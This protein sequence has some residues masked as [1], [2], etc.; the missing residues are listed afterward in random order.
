M[1]N[2]GFE[3][4][5]KK[6]GY[7]P[8]GQPDLEILKDL[9]LTVKQG[10]F[11]TI[12]GGNGTGKSTLLKAIAGEI[13][14]ATGSIT[15]GGSHIKEPIHRRIDGVGI[16]HQHD[17]EDL[18]HA[19]SIAMNVAFRQTN[20]GC[21]P[22][23]F[24]A[25][26]RRYCTRLQKQLAEHASQLGKDVDQL[27]GHL[28]G[29]ERQM[30]NMVIATHLEHEQNP[31]RLILLD[32]HTSKLDHDNAHAV[33]EF[34]KAQIN[35]IGTTAIMVTHRYPDAIKYSDRIVVMGGGKIAKEFTAKDS[36]WS[37][38]MLAQAVEENS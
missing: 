22:H 31:C 27:V 8:Q 14:L 5:C 4:N 10:E 7:S 21:H 30:L 20:N 37:V 29:G 35:E 16:V 33:M 38:D 3:V 19:F 25:C 11:L 34:T 24:W 28:S 12:I 23:M 13:E 26:S 2:K 6:L 17:D 15:V 1:R 32:E 18:L 36:T 9:D